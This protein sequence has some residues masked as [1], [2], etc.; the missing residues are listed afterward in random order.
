MRILF[1]TLFVLFS[2]TACSSDVSNE[3]LNEQAKKLLIDFHKANYEVKKEDY[4]KTPDDFTAY[5]S[6]IQ[7]KV[8]PYLTG[9]E[10]EYLDKESVGFIAAYLA[11]NDIFLTVEG[12][13]ITDFKRDTVSG[14]IDISYKISLK[15][16]AK[17]DVILGV[18]QV[19]LLPENETFKIDRYW[20]DFKITQFINIKS[21]E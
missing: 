17:N 18:A 5:I 7:K 4:I 6:V 19:T 9:K 1:T 21:D 11:Y 15:N 8:T 3:E 20:D 10:I 2:L 14:S 16:L 12:I 13:E